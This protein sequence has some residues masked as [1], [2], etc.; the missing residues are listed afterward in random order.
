MKTAAE[1]V[2]KIA[3]E[4]YAST[5]PGRRRIEDEL[6]LLMDDWAT[7]YS[8]GELAQALDKEKARLE[9]LD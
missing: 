7:R 3:A 6:A 4:R 5:W 8:F 9:L 2:I 1:L